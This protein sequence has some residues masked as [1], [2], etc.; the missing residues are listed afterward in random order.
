MSGIPT[1]ERTTPPGARPWSDV[2][3]TR[4]EGNAYTAA[5]DVSRTARNGPGFINTATVSN[6]TASKVVVK[7]YD[8]TAASGGEIFTFVVPPNDTRSAVLNVAF[9]TGLTFAIVGTA[10]ASVVVS[11]SVGN[12]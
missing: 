7:A 5:L 12:P 1:I 9:F 4:V 10:S 6:D 2:Q 3:S 8:N 11:A